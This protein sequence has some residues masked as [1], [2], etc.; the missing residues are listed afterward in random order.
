MGVRPTSLNKLARLP[1]QPAIDCAEPARPGALKCLVGKAIG[2][3]TPRFQHQ[4]TRDLTLHL[5]RLREFGAVSAETLG[6]DRGPYDRLPSV[7]LGCHAKP[8]NP[9]GATDAW[10]TVAASAL[11]CCSALAVSE[12]AGKRFIQ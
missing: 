1:D 6:D 8:C 10:R 2:A 7:A 3:A 4:S 12:S 5:E 9:G 11:N